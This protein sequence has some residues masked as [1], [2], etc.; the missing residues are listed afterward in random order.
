[1]THYQDQ[2][3]PYYFE[4]K[5][6]QERI[7]ENV[8]LIK[9]GV[10]KFGDIVYCSKILEEVT[11][12]EVLPSDSIDYYLRN[13]DHYTFS[14]FT[15]EI[16]YKTKTGEVQQCPIACISKIQKKNYSHIYKV[17][18]KKKDAKII[19]ENL[20]Y[21]GKAN[22]FRV[23][24]LETETHFLLTFFGDSKIKVKAFICGFHLEN[25]SKFSSS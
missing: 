6:S 19:V 13:K 8:K 21:G 14:P 5:T 4:F 9:E 10:I 17:Q 23:Q 18:K 20:E 3:N 15:G 11:F 1:M 16:K 22:G 12:L 2:Y 24:V 7:D 25:R